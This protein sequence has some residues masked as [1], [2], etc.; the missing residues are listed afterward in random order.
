MDLQTEI[1]VVYDQQLKTTKIY[2]DI[3]EH[4]R[5]TEAKLKE[6]IAEAYYKGEI[7]GKNATERSA[8]EVEMFKAQHKYLEN[9]KKREAYAYLEKELAEIGVER[10]R[11]LLRVAE[12]SQV[13]DTLF[14][15]KEN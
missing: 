13:P 11:A 14:F 8:A 15:N 10:V 2:R 1:R 7:Q 9:L 12:L 5:Q 3:A 4:L 6:E